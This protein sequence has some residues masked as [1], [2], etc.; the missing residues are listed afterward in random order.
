LLLAEL[1]R[2]VVG[3]DPAEASLQVARSKPSAARVNRVHGDATT[4][5]AVGADLA[6]LT[7]NVAQVFLTDDDWTRALQDIHAPLRP[8]GYL[9]FETRRPQHRAWEQW[10][11]NAGEVRLDMWRDMRALRRGHGAAR[12]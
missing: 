10:A 11:A 5:P 9:V 8:R 1:G 4:L 3:V 6:V 2:T 12:P 7:G